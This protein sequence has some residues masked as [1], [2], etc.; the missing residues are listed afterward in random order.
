MFTV[1]VILP[2]LGNVYNRWYLMLESVADHV[3]WK[4]GT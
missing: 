3:G 4:N 1:V 2:G